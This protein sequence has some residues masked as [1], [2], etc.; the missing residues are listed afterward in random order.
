MEIDGSLI[1]SSSQ[2][3][4]FDQQHPFNSERKCCGVIDNSECL[5]QIQN[6]DCM[7]VISDTNITDDSFI[8]YPLLSQEINSDCPKIE[9]LYTDF[10][11]KNKMVNR[12][13]YQ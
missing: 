2:S 1:E 12:Q 3:D 13:K 10:F 4:G 7:E 8:N 6:D 11:L 9:N 5:D